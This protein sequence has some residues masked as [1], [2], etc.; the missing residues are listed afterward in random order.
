MKKVVSCCLSFV[1]VVMI[2]LTFV[3][4]LLAMLIFGEGTMSTGE[5]ILMI[6]LLLFELIGVVMTFVMMIWYMIKT[7]KN[8]EFS[9]GIKVLWCALLYCF[10]MF[11]F[12]VYWFMYVRK[13]E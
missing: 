4:L 8:P 13:E 6:G 9:T 12:P 7:C 11:I 10:N 1:P 3:V 2:V 5:V